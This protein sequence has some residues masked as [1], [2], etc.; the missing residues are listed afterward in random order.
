MKKLLFLLILAL[1]VFLTWSFSKWET[2][3]EQPEQQL[4]QPN[5]EQ[6]AKALLARLVIPSKD[7][8]ELCKKYPDIVTRIFKGKKI[9]VSGVLTKALPTSVNSNNLALEL[10]GSPGLKIMFNSDYQKLLKWVVSINKVQYYKFHRESKTIIFSGYLSAIT[11]DGKKIERKSFAIPICTEGDHI[12]LHGE[13]RNIAPGWVKCDLL[14]VP[15]YPSNI[16]KK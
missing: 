3:C 10:D 7:L 13:F 2:V 15:N 4:L 1:I 8:S 5:P 16:T 14:E 6:E 12:T 9:Y 11:S